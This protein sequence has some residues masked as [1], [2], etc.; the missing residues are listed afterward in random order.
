MLYLSIM[1]PISASP[2]KRWPIALRVLLVILVCL[3]VP[4]VAVLGWYVAGR[5]G[6]ARVVARLKAQ[7]RARGEPLTLAE[8]G[9]TQP[10]IPDA[11]NAAMAL[12]EAWKRENPEVWT[13]VLE[14]KR[15]IPDQPQEKY[16]EALPYLG[17][18][19][20]VARGEPLS[21][22]A[23][24]AARKFLAERGDELKQVRAALQKPKCRFPVRLEDEGFMTPLT[25]LAAMKREAQTFKIESVLAADQGRVDE[26]I[27]SL[28]NVVGIGNL[29]TQEPTL[30]SHLVRIACLSIAVDGAQQLLSRQ[31]L[32]K[33]QLDR[34]AQ[35]C[36]KTRSSGALRTA[37]IGER[38]CALSVFDMSG[39][40]LLAF[41]QM[42][43]NPSATSYQAQ[44]YK[45]GMK[46]MAA[47]G[48]RAADER[49]MLEVL[50]EM[51]ALSDVEPPESVRRAEALEKGLEKR[52][53]SFPPKIMC[54]LLLPAGAKTALKFATSEA[55]RRSALVAVAIE[56]HRL[57]HNGA[58]PADLASLVPQ[59]LKEVPLDPYDGQ[60][61]RYAQR[62]KGYVVYSVGVDRRDDGGKLRT[63]GKPQV[64]W[65]ETFAVER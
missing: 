3:A 18:N 35:V 60:P 52:I 2:R 62:P 9:A 25:H 58:L 65:D 41:N 14:N 37:M 39:E 48:L 45:L 42:D 4:I 22:E 33:E 13:A 24:E 17:K 49:L 15:P 63:P 50:G 46:V 51:I 54:G 40:Q 26:S 47:V 57:D 43:G 20:K 59:Y 10:K 6:D 64:G 34:L 12:I 28:G 11:E 36:E 21:D 30:I 19:G 55:L 7:A 16:D 38:V 61:I 32:S 56:R 53:H 27:A 29:L 1:N 31:T 8:L 5:V 23:K 44:G